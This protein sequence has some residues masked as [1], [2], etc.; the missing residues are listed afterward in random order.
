M[1]FLFCGIS[2]IREHVLFGFNQI[3]EVSI[4]NILIGVE[5]SNMVIIEQLSICS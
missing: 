2:D 1:N 5:M 4:V 3:V